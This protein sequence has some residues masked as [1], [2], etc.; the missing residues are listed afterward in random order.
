MQLVGD[1]L[2]VD[3]DVPIVDFIADV[4]H[5]EGFQVR[6]ANSGAE[7]LEAIVAQRPDLILSDLH[8]PGMNGI[9]LIHHLRQHGLADV[10]VVIMTADIQA[11]GQLAAEQIVDCL[12]KPFTIDDLLKSIARCIQPHPA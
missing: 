2:V 10:P 6:V 3:D 1:I 5:E 11:A 7:A 9:A 8:M 4:L 12:F